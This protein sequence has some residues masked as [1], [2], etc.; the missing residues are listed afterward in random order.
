MKGKRELLARFMDVSGLGAALRAAARWQGLLILNYHRVA[1]RAEEVLDPGVW[2]ATPDDLDRQLA[3]L[4]RHTDLLRPED[5][6]AAL[7]KPGR[8]TLITFDDGYR[9]NYALAF[10]ILRAQGVAALFFPVTGYLDRPLVPGWDEVAWMLARAGREAERVTLLRRRRTLDPAGQEALLDEL[11]AE[12]GVGRAPAHLADELWMTWDMAREMAAAGQVFGG[13]TDGHPRLSTLDEAAQRA[14]IDGCLSR[15]KI[16]LGEPIEWF[17]YPFGGSDAFDATTR[18]L[19]SAA[20]VRFACTQ[21]GGHHRRGPYDALALP[22]LAVDREAP[23]MFR[24]ALAY[25]TV[26]ARA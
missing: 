12:T 3:L 14:E 2:S 23:A 8:Y 7:E 20:G 4:R 21:H 25:P 18:R 9:D 5:V 22:R 19:L 16:E 1:H 15:L 10:P 17:S 26:F 6:A 11:A 24:A 13:H